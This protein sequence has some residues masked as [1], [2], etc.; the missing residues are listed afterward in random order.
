MHGAYSFQEVVDALPSPKI[1]WLMLPAGDTVDT[2]LFAKG[3]FASLVSKGDIIIDGGNSFYKD[4]I[5]RAKKLKAK[6]I[7]YID[8]GTREGEGTLVN[9]RM[10]RDVLIEKGYHLDQELSWVEDKG[11]MHNEAAWGRRFRQALPFL[12]S[13]SVK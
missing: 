9:A 2:A 3:G 12:L 1:I 6:G 7:I 13:G 10:M 8:V 11:G 4:T 5:R